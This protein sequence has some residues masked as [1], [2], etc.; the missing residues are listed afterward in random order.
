[1]D[2]EQEGEGEKGSQGQ[3]QKGR[4]SLLSCMPPS[5]RRAVVEK[6]GHSTII[7][8]QNGFYLATTISYC[9]HFEIPFVFSCHFE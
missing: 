9:R 1:M 4:I 5:S 8:W 2:G 6:T 3:S 7:N